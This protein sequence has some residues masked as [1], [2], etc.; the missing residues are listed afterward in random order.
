MC[1]EP[2]IANDYNDG[3]ERKLVIHP[4]FAL[5]AMSVCRFVWR[6]RTKIRR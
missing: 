6:K 5:E 3:E 4:D 2:I 1:V